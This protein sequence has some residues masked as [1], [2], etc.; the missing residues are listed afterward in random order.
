MVP[1][2]D[3]NTKG[4]HD[5]NIRKNFDKI[6]AVSHE[7]ESLPTT[8]N[9]ADFLLAREM[10]ISDPA[11]CRSIILSHKETKLLMKKEELKKAGLSR[12]RIYTMQP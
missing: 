9:S 1:V 3:N 4:W 8:Y 5:H 10:G 6:V 12:F 2:I 7:T 11:D